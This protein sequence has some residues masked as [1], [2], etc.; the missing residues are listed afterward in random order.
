MAINAKLETNYGEERDLYIRLNNLE[1][2]SKHAGAV[3]RFRGFV[4][5]KAFKAGKNYVWEKLVE[6]P[7]DIGGNLAEQAYF[8]L[9]KEISNA[10]DA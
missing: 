8:V 6:F 9:K 2:V 5:E 1:T 7:C 4:S 3:A 10:V